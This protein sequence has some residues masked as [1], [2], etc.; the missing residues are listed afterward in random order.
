[1]HAAP[2]LEEEGHGL[3]EA[4]VAERERPLGLHWSCAGT[5]LAADDGPVDVRQ[6]KDPRVREQRLERNEPRAGGT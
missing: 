6:I 3:P 2:L 1:V 4:L 5:G